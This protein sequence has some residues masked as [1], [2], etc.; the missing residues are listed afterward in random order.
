[1]QV[2]L[3]RGWPEPSSELLGESAIVPES[4]LEGQY[5]KLYL[6]AEPGRDT[7]SIHLVGDTAYLPLPT[8]ETLLRGIE[9][10]VLEAAYRDVAVA[11]IPALT[12]LSGLART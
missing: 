6:A 2:V 4:T 10:I 9:K 3:D 11:D 1:M 8:M 7:C 12:G 5:C